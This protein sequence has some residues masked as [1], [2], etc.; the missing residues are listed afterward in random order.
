MVHSYH[1]QSNASFKKII[2]NG[3]IFSKHFISTRMIWYEMLLIRLVYLTVKRN[4]RNLRQRVL[5]IFRQHYETLP[6]NRLSY[7]LMLLAFIHC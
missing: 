6:T 5:K 3:A 1:G 2:V 4:P 7:P